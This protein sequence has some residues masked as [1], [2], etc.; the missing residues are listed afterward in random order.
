MVILMIFGTC[1]MILYALCMF[2]VCLEVVKCVMLVEER[3][4]MDRNEIGI[5][6]N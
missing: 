1:R 6:W 2:M 3:N 4:Q 5:E